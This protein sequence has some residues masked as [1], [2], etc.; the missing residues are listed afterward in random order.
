MPALTIAYYQ[1]N[2]KI[3]QYVGFNA[4]NLTNKQGG[5]I[6][7]ATDYAMTKNASTSGEPGAA[8][9]L[10]PV[11]AAVAAVYGDPSG[12]YKQYLEE[13]VMITRPVFLLM[14]IF[15]TLCVC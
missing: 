9:E 1:T 15:F 12:K 7:K 4:W 13:C 11:V 2:A 3:G 10:F 8:S 5:T 14:M 6:Q